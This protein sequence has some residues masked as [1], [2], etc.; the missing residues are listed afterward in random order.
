M[1]RG[2]RGPAR[3]I[4]ARRA[5]AALVGA[6]ALVLS[7]SLAHPAGAADLTSLQ[8]RVDQARSQ[9]RSLAAGV[10]LRTAELEAASARAAAAGARQQQ[11]EA[12]LA[13]GRE[14][15]ARLR[16]AAAAAHE[17]LLEAQA[18]YRR[19]QRQLG[20]RL[21]AIYKS[22]APD[23]VT[24]LLDADGFSDLL[25]RAAY[26]KEISAADNE[27]LQRVQALRDGVRSWLERV[28]GLRGQATSEV[29]RIAA[30]RDEV[31]SIRAA[32][33]G[34]AASLQRA[35]AA[36]QAS[37]SALRSRM[38]GWTAQVQ[39]LQAATGGP[40]AG[41]TIGKWLGDF[42][43]PS[44]VVMCES[45]GNYGA[46]N[47]KSGAGGAYQMMP[48]T[49]KGLGGRYAAPQVAPKWEQDQL[50]Q[51]LWAGGRGAGNW[52]CAK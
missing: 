51:K 36:Q 2:G 33:Q 13:E 3:Q 31:A 49:Y 1:K 50:A 39:V 28:R 8:A 48:E 22:D 6:L 9:A 29:V 52:A 11:L 25:T 26:L 23:L 20:V 42:S 40:G 43:I 14:R 24:V 18:R 30:A 41:Q 12:T 17:R 37:L 19:S 16:A 10:Q 45:G 47:P 7:L 32:E 27:L 38:A 21:V 15:L 4:A 35:R 46:V 44:S 34:R 5:S